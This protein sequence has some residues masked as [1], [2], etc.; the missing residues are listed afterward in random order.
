MSLSLSLSLSLPALCSSLLVFLSGWCAGWL[1]P[2]SWPS[3]RA[4]CFRTGGSEDGFDVA[5]IFLVVRF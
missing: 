2:L 5:S 4:S 1:H 3:S